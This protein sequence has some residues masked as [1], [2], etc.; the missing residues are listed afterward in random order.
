MQRKTLGVF[1]VYEMVD[2]AVQKSFQEGP[3]LPRPG[4]RAG[5]RKLIAAAGAL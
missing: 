1:P 3:Y 5:R 2:E 4:M